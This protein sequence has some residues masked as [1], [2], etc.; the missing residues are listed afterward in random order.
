MA[1]DSHNKKPE[2]DTEDSMAT[3]GPKFSLLSNSDQ[4]IQA[5]R[6][7]E[8]VI[9]VPHNDFVLEDQQWKLGDCDWMV[10]I[11]HM[12]YPM[13]RSHIHAKFSHRKKLYMKL[14]TEA[15]VQPTDRKFVQLI[16]D[17]GGHLPNL[18]SSSFQA[19]ENDVDRPQATCVWPKLI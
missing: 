15:N 12:K 9:E 7:D 16:F 19:G 6:K 1:N 11:L 18:Q 5:T 13:V 17:P 2:Q 10:Q 4:N 3:C 8:Q 14:C